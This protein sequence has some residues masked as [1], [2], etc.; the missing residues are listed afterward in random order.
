MFLDKRSIMSANTDH[1]EV[2]PVFRPEVV[3][4]LK[5]PRITTPY[6]RKYEYVALMAARQQ[7]IADGAK[8]L[9]SLDG[10]RTSDPRFLDQVVK[11]EIEQR[12]LPFLFRRQMPNGTSEFWSAQELELAW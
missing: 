4:A 6:F 10:L 1:P 7:Q 9:V 12:K 2:S 11:R 8:P 3:D 5:T